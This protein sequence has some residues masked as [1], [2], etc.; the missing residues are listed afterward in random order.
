GEYEAEDVMD[1]DGV[2]DEPLPIRVR[3]RIA[4]DAVDVD[5]AGTAPQAKGGV[6]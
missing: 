5:F 6:N 4:G 1:D 3:V 2:G